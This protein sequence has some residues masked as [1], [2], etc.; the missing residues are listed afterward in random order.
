MKNLFLAA[1][2]ALSL[3]AGVANAAPVGDHSTVAGD[4]SATLMQQSESG[5]GGG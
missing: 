1:L 2:A 3:G 4:R 5:G